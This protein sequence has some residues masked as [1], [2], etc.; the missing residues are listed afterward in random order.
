MGSH[1]Q[2]H[3]IAIISVA[4]TIAIA[5]YSYSIH[6]RRKFSLEGIKKLLSDLDTS[7]ANGPDGVPSF[8]LKHC[9]DEIV[10]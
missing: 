2:M 10:C 8:I 5:R 7:K 3:Q 4:I 1:F 6:A 9:A